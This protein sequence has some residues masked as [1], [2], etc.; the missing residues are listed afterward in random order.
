MTSIPK[1][2]QA[3]ATILPFLRELD[4]VR[5]PD[6][7]DSQEIT[8]RIQ[9]LNQIC[10]QK[11]IKDALK[12]NQGIQ[13]LHLYRD[14]CKRLSDL[15]LY[16]LAEVHL[17][18]GSVILNLLADPNLSATNTKPY[19]MIAMSNSLVANLLISILLDREKQNFTG[20][21]K[22][23]GKLQEVTA[24]IDALKESSRKLITE[25]NKLGADMGKIWN[26]IEISEDDFDRQ[27][28]TVTQY[29]QDFHD[30]LVFY[31]TPLGT[32]FLEG[33]NENDPFNIRVKYETCF[34]TLPNMSE[35]SVRFLA[36][37]YSA[38][39]LGRQQVVYEAFLDRNLHPLIIADVSRE[40]ALFSIGAQAALSR[41]ID[42]LCKIR[43]ESN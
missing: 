36:G 30:Q 27:C 35:S 22:K 10:E 16:T 3:A 4:K 28:S 18:R 43:L 11:D 7:C 37:I 2:K 12:I 15:E 32:Y 9:A 17:V 38:A 34:E 20:S 31:G 14:E 40:N 19:I 21:S 1:I 23:V 6:G 5:F 24:A 13:D 29:T 26:N 41:G 25:L 8:V 42:N 33:A 39:S